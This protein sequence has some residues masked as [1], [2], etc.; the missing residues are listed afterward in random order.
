MRLPTGEI[1]ELDGPGTPPLGILEDAH[2]VEHETEIPAGSLLLLY[3]DG[4]IERRD[5]DLTEG[6]ERLKEVFV[7][8]PAGAVDCLD[9]IDE[10]LETDSIPDDVAMLAM[11]VS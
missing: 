2:C 3:T 11:A 1:V 7:A 10:R 8:A 9:W 5:S 6:L 4:L